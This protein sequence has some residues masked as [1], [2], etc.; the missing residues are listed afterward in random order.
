MLLAVVNDPDLMVTS[1]IC[2]EHV[3]ISCGMCSRGTCVS[4]TWFH[5]MICN[6]SIEV[7]NNIYKRHI[8]KDFD[9]VILLVS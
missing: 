7:V 4:C 6:I 9:R 2:E 8:F 3:S 1:T 5:A